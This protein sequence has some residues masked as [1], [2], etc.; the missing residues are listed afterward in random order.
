MSYFNRLGIRNLSTGK[1][2]DDSNPGKNESDEKKAKEKKLRPASKSVVVKVKNEAGVTK[3][4]AQD[5][6]DNLMKSAKNIDSVGPND[7]QT[8]SRNISKPKTFI[9]QSARTQPTTV[10]AFPE[11]VEPT[12]K[13]AKILALSGW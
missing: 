13:Y 7:K 4:D 12:D 10:K 6:M 2:S 1:E 8:L 11:E 5:K 9:R 3:K